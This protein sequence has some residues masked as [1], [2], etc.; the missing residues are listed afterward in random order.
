MTHSPNGYF[1][2]P[3]F[4]QRD[5]IT[6]IEHITD[7]FIKLRDACRALLLNYYHAYKFT[8]SNDCDIPLFFMREKYT[9]TES[10]AKEG[11]LAQGSIVIKRSDMLALKKK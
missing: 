11:H 2:K 10:V 3:S 8:R 5:D 1:E 6:I 7:E 4:A 9:V